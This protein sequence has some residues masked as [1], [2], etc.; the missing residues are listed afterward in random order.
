MEQLQRLELLIG[1]DKIQKIKDSCVLV[2]GLGGVGSYAVEALVRSGIG[3]IILVDHD[4][5]NITNLNRQLMTNHL[6]L[7][8]YKTDALEE[9]I[10]SINPNCLVQKITNYI[11]P[12]NIEDLFVNKIDYIVDA[13]DAVPTKK[14]LIRQ[15]LKRNIKFICSM[16]MG[17]RLDPSLI[18]IIDIR[19]TN[20]DPLAKIIRKMVKD[21]HINKKIYVVTS[22]EV[23]IKTN[24]K[25]IGSTVFVPATA[26]LRLASFV[27]NDIIKEKK[28]EKN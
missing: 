28:H 7:E 11:T 2:L 17:N 26:G 15:C 20:N 22:K 5:I 23:P 14:E 16:G 4:K 10:N 6:N 12:D 18:E 19:K 25:I 9:R 24:T 27:I 3:K 21:E 8:Q 1:K 13:C